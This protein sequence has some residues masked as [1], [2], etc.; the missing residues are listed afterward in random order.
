MRPKP[1]DEEDEAC[2][3]KAEHARVSAEHEDDARNR[4]RGGYLRAQDPSMV[5]PPLL[6][7]VADEAA[8]YAANSEDSEANASEKACTETSPSSQLEEHRGEGHGAMRNQG[9]AICY[10]KKHKGWNL[11]FKQ[12]DKKLNRIE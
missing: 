7:A 5:R 8:E 11:S 6:Q 2:T 4:N 10:G 9:E 12:Q 1:A 3:Q